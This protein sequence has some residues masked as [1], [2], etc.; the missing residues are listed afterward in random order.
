MRTL[1][2]PFLLLFALGVTTAVHADDP[3]PSGVVLD[4]RGPPNPPEGGNFTIT[5]TITFGGGL[6]TDVCP[7]CY[8]GGYNPTKVAAA[9]D[10]WQTAGYVVE[11]AGDTRIRLIGRKDKQGKVYPVTGIK[12]ESKDLPAEQLPKVVPDAKNMG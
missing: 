2:I 6:Q 10:G 7:I 8:G 4:L 11:K 3:K 5:F 9:M 1:T 12:I